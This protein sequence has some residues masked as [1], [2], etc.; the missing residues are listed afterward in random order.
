MALYESETTIEPTL[1]TYRLHEYDWEQYD[2]L[3][4]AFEWEVPDAFNIATYICDRWANADPARVA[5]VAVDVDGTTT[6]YKFEELRHL[7]DR[8]AHFLDSEGIEKGDR[9][10]V[11][12]AQ[13]I[14]CL[15]THLAA[16]K[17]GAV[18]VPLSLLFGPDGLKYRLQDSGA[19]AF[20]ASET[21]LSSLREIRSDCTALET[22]LTLDGNSAEGE[23]IS[24]WEAISDR[25]AI[26]EAVRTDAK[27]PALILYTS[28]TTG[29]PK[30]VVHAQR[31]LLGHLPLHVTTLRNMDIR[32]DDVLYTPGEWSWVGPLYGYVLAGLYYGTTIIGDANPQFD[33]ERTLEFVERYE[34]TNVAGPT[35]VYRVL[36]Q[37]P[38]AS[39]RFDLSSLRVAFEGG[40]SLGQTV[41]DW[42]RDVVGAEAV[43]EGYGQTEAGVF[44]GDCE[45]LGVDHRSDCMGK[46]VP[47]SEVRIV[48]P[49]SSISI[50]PGE[51]GEIALRYEDNPGC[52]VKYWNE[53]EKT[54]EKTQ[55][56][57]LLTE[58]LGAIT[59]DDYVSF[60]S[61][62]DDVII[63]SGY[64][65][66][67]SEIEEFLASHEA[68][69]DAGVIGVP[70]ETRGEIPKA[71]VVPASD[72]EPSSELRT[73]LQEHVKN[74]LAKHE[75]PRNL[76][77]IDGLPQT[78]TGKV[79]RRDLRIREGL[80]EED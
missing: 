38:N 1:E 26:P 54:A 75:Y 64:R 17:L 5:M 44:I 62:A 20:V 69:A 31:S 51:V 40:E 9:I 56:G 36:M 24:L 52:F 68:V 33:P 78:T 16:W 58:D 73:E 13:R 66:G 49:G 7:A 28:G 43:H 37:V 71:F 30:G 14:E 74:R 12:G 63:S 76:E 61:R 8:L 59:P 45:A 46:P 15:A 11:S 3:Y 23:E 60:Y 70:D 21:S 80:I 42:L 18:T 41:A 19:A 35:T 48:E 72:H 65:I 67:P 47:G 34:V 29:P 57:W 25:P 53:P 2:E 79:R 4:E 6:E 10:A 77:F 55:D 27:D 50:D 32:A 22:V 39:Q